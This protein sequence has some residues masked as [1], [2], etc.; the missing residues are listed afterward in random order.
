M[1]A[2]APQLAREN[3]VV[4]TLWA[5]AGAALFA[6]MWVLPKLAGGD[7]VPLQ[8]GFL[9]YA[10]GAVVVAPLFLHD[11]ARAAPAAAAVGRSRLIGL[12]VL[13][14]GFGATSLVLGTYA[15]THIPL[16]NAQAIAMTHGV[17]TVIFAV[18]FLKERI[19][20]REVAAAAIA[21]TGAVLVAGPGTGGGWAELGAL[22]AILQAAAWGGE[23]AILKATA[24]R[25]RPSRILLVV[26]ASAAAML[27]IAGVWWWRTLPVATWLMLLA[28]GP[29]AIAGQL[30]NIRAFRLANASALVP[31]GYAGMVFAGLFGFLLFGEVPRA[32]AWLGAAMIA[33]GALWLA[34]R[35]VAAPGGAR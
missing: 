1:T 14:A 26:N 13:R 12:H 27:F 6:F 2:M 21:L 5:A 28:M 34:C 29:V 15:V 11:A 19:G 17:F 25:D 7:L 18:A 35:P 32:V 33:G 22:A 30:C 16:A 24:V 23:V 9:R 20:V 4:A 3:P 10:A 31:I 8:V